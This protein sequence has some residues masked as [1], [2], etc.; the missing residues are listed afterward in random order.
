MYRSSDNVLTNVTY[1]KGS[2]ICDVLVQDN[3][4]N[5]SIITFQG[6][7]TKLVVFVTQ[8]SGLLVDLVITGAC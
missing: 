3:D 5:F 4:H 7:S 8:L 1:P 2:V 6:S